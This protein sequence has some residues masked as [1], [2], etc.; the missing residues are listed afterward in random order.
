MIASNV[1]KEG[2]QLPAPT[3]ATVTVSTMHVSPV[4]LNLIRAQGWPLPYAVAGQRLDLCL[5]TATLG[6]N[7]LYD[8]LSE[9]RTLG[10]SK[11]L[12][13]LVRWAC[14]ANVEHL[15]IDADAELNDR[16]PLFVG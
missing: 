10:F 5:P 13:H 16:L 12:T 9:L 14:D 2:M 7:S 1:R 3:V 15:R 8:F 6:S 4:D 11:P